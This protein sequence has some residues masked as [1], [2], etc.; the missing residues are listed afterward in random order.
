MKTLIPGPRRALAAL[1]LCLACSASC[2]DSDEGLWTTA[3][4]GG[5]LNENWKA[6]VALQTR[7]FDGT[8]RLDRHLIRPSVT[9][10]LGDG[11]SITLGYDAH[12]VDE[13]R[14]FVEQR[15]WQQY[16]QSWP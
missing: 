2:A 9:R 16:Q 8:G 11:R 3:T 1:A 6:S 14:G 7:F 4:V 13:P 12:F 10:L 5:T 15:L